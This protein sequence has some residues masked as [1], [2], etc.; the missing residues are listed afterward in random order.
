MSVVHFLRPSTRVYKRIGVLDTE[1]FVVVYVTDLFSTFPFIKFRQ[2]YMVG[3]G[4]NDTWVRKE[5]V[6]DESVSKK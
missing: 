3:P 6:T 4:P 1:P 2:K 5:S